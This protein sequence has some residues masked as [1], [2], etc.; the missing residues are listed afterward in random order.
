M[1]YINTTLPQGH[2]IGDYEIED[3]G[4]GTFTL[5]LVSNASKTKLKT[6]DNI[7]DLMD[8]IK[9]EHPQ[10]VWGNHRCSNINVK[11]SAA[12]VTRTL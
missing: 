4:D 9:S 6:L 1:E 8:S 2:Y 10:W 3:N 11:V 12:A 7:Q 5:S